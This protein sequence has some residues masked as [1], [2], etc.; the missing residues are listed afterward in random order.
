MT[1]GLYE[2]LQVVLEEGLDAA[3]AR[4][5]LNHRAQC[6]ASSGPDHQRGTRGGDECRSCRPHPG[7]VIQHLRAHVQRRAK[8]LLKGVSNLVRDI[9]GVTGSR[10]PVEE[11]QD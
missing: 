3:F 6:A 5:A 2:A 8:P 4:H 9:L 10:G 1:Y 11:N 7:V